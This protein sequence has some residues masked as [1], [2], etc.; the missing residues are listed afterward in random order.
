MYE[1]NGK[2]KEYSDDDNNLVYEGEYLN[3]KR[4]GKGKEFINDWLFYEGEYLNGKRNGKG[5]TYYPNRN[6]MFEGEF[7]NGKA[8][9][10]MDIIPIIK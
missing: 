6:P 7:L 5:K 10:E 2:A 3:G 1:E 8:G 4:N 9:K